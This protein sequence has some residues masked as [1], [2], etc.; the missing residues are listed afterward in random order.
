VNEGYGVMTVAFLL[1]VGAVAL[2]VL[3]PVVIALICV[4]M[5]NRRAKRMSK[6]N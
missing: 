6:S 2:V 5:K 4:W 1:M 3:L